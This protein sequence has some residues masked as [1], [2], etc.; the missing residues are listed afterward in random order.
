MEKPH[1]ADD[2]DP[3]GVCWTLPSRISILPQE[4][5]SSGKTDRP[6]TR[7]I[8]VAFVGAIIT[9]L[10]MVATLEV[11]HRK[12]SAFVSSQEKYV[13]AIEAAVLSIFLV[14]M[15]V[16]LVAL[17]FSTARLT[18]RGTRLR[19]IVRIVGYSIALLSIVS[20]LA[21]NAAL[22]ISVGAIVGVVV[23]L[24]AQTIVGSILAT[25]LIIST[26]MVRV[27]EEITVNQTKGT[28]WEIN[29]THTM[30]VVG[31]DVIFVPNSLIISTL[32]RRKRRETDAISRP[33]DQKDGD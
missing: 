30:M 11:S 13:V 12:A 7:P 33:T 4:P 17:R 2:V 29:L 27:G 8:V 19:L 26:R 21:S 24:A 28:I 3:V 22:G 10:L 20:I 9:I 5:D 23:A 14:E 18:E 32:V 6:K 25:V 15:L 16:R 1:V 31:D